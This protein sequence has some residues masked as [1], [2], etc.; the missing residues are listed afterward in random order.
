M[1]IYSEVDARENIVQ[2]TKKLIKTVKPSQIDMKY[3]DERFK[4]NY[5]FPDPDMGIY[6]GKSFFLHGYPPWQ[7]RI[8]EFFNI[9]THHN[10]NFKK[11]ILLMRQ[12]SKCER[13][14]GK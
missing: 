7:I 1:N 4:E 14:L 13:R 12:F 10:I 5:E 8:T 11:F 6:F 3:L 9:K 2:E